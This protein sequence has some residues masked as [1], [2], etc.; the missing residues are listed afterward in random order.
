MILV[1]WLA[2]LLDSFARLTHSRRVE[3]LADAV[4]RVHFGRE[5]RTAAKTA[6]GAT[7]VLARN[8]AELTPVTDRRLVEHFGG[9]DDGEMRPLCENGRRAGGLYVVVNENGVTVGKRF[10]PNRTGS[11][12]H[13]DR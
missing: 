11:P 3:R 13:R 12:I 6:R 1:L 8:A 10:M 9:P 5:N 2:R 7:L 4:Y